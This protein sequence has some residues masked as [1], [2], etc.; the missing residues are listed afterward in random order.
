MLPQVVSLSVGKGTI[1]KWNF[2]QRK[3]KDIGVADFSSW[4]RYRIFRGWLY[5]CSAVF[6]LYQFLVLFC[7][8]GEVSS[9]E[10]SQRTVV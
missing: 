6:L 9:D 5:A 3:E 4:S 10:L 1:K 2:K 7:Q 8:F